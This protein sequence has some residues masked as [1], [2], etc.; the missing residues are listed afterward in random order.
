M[1]KKTTKPQTTEQKSKMVKQFRAGKVTATV[2]E[3]EMTQDGKTFPI[4]AIKVT[5]SYSLDDGKTWQDTNNF[6]RDELVK[7]QIVVNKAIE[8]M[9][10][11]E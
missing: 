4:Y 3:K 1:E 6:T 10:L 5:K 2:F 7:I 9:Y 8:F 11:T